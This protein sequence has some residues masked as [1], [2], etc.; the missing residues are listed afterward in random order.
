MNSNLP[1]LICGAG[2][3]GLTL[4][5]E[6]SRFGVP[7]RIVDRATEPAAGSRALTLQAR[8]LELLEACRITEQLLPFANIVRFVQVRTGDHTLIEVAFDG[9]PTAY[10]FV[11]VVPQDATERTMIVRLLEQGTEVER[12]VTLTALVAADDGVDVQLTHADGRHERLRCR[13]LAACDGADSTIR[14]ALD[15]PLA[16]HTPAEQFT[17]ADVQLDTALRN[18]TVTVALTT[19]GGMVALIPMAGGWRVTIE[20]PAALGDDIHAAEL[21]RVLDAHRLPGRVL[22]VQWTAGYRMGQRKVERYVVGR[23]FLLGDAAQVNTPIGGQ[24]LNA[25][26]GDAVNLGWKL[27][28]VVNDGVDERLLATY[29]DER[30]TVGR[31]L[32]AATDYGNRLAFNAN[33][34]VRALRN[35]VSPL[36]TR[37]PLVRDRLRENVAGLRIAYPRSPLSINGSPAHHGIRAGMRVRGHRPAVHHPQTVVVPQGEHEAPMTVVVRPDGYAGYVAHGAHTGGAQ[38][39]LRNVLGIL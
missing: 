30:E 14:R 19:D 17:L 3:T 34:A 12:G 29:H 22:D 15:V 39:Y 38:T 10:S 35:A 31:A 21:Q 27:A 5:L 20:S 33:T 23:T 18:D 8:T 28:L 4:A 11:A 13:Y 24:G 37:L 16:G 9:M 2:P 6:L 25:G 1:V 32:L 36:A 26:I 7:F